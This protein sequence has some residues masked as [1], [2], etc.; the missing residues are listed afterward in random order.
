MARFSIFPDLNSLAC[1]AGVLFSACGGRADGEPS[2]GAAGHGG[3]GGGSSDAGAASGG[4][5]VAGA[6]GKSVV[7]LSCDAWRK[8][9]VETL[10]S[11]DLILD[12]LVVTGAGYYGLYPGGATGPLRQAV[13]VVPPSEV[14]PLAA[15]SSVHSFLS[16]NETGVFWVEGPNTDTP[17]LLYRFMMVPAQGGAAQAVSFTTEPLL[18]FRATAGALYLSTDSTREGPYAGNGGLRRHT[19]GGDQLSILGSDEPVAFGVG[20]SAIYWFDLSGNQI[21]VLDESSSTPRQLGTNDRASSFSPVVLGGMLYWSDGGRLLRLPTA[22]GEVAA[23]ASTPYSTALIATADAL[24]YS[25]VVDGRPAIFCL[26][27]DQGAPVQLTIPSL[28]SEVASVRYY[29]GQ[30]HIL[31][32]SDTKSTL[33]SLTPAK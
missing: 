4:V 26:P 10:Q 28:K 12:D 13:R 21:W 15:S 29:G 24:L 7:G 1:V 5:S 3:E 23:C 33:L 19:I 25:A 20:S 18:D 32:R 8:P 11:F 16:V 31:M 17:E 22:G 14:T 6:G 30:I 2:A 27:T 9:P